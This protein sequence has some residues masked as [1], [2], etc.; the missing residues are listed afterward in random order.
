MTVGALVLAE[1]IVGMTE[2]SAMRR[3]STPRLELQGLG[4]VVLNVVERPTQASITTGRHG[5]HHR[6]RQTLAA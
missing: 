3:P 5:S 4:V 1:G 2:A 6:F